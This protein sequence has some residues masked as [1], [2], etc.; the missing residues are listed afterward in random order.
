ML[1]HD[2]I[3]PQC[4]TQAVASPKDA[5]N[6]IWCPQCNWEGTLQEVSNMNKEQNISDQTKLDL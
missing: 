6:M 4:G 2:R 1:N 5:R 3:C